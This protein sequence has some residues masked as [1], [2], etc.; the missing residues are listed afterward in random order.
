MTIKLFWALELSPI[1]FEDNYLPEAHC[2]LSQQLCTLPFL[3]Q[4]PVL[5]GPSCCPNIIRSMNDIPETLGARTVIHSVR[6][7]E[8]NKHEPHSNELQT[9][10]NTFKSCL[11]AFWLP[12]AP[13][14]SYRVFIVIIV[15]QH[16]NRPSDPI[17][18][19]RPS[20]STYLLSANIPL[21]LSY[22]CT[23][24]NISQMSR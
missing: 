11:S 5:D 21:N 20:S 23:S 19:H 7:D 22:P 12:S 13:L 15:S 2:R 9:F 3:F 14:L 24:R 16:G 17:G 1:M 10:W 8:S 4:S 18:P 6:R